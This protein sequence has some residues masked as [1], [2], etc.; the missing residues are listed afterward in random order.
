MDVGFY[1]SS[2]MST[3]VAWVTTDY[4]KFATNS[5][6]VTFVVGIKFAKNGIVYNNRDYMLSGLPAYTDTT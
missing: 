1:D 6:W 5:A 4:S 2:A 3:T